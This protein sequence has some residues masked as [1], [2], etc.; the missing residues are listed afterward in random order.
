MKRAMKKL[1]EQRYWDS[2]HQQTG[3]AAS[4]PAKQARDGEA[5]VEATPGLKAKIKR[6]LGRDLLERMT[7]YDDY[8]LHEVILKTHLPETVAPV[9]FLEVGSAPGLNLVYINKT[10]GYD[11]YGIDYSEVGVKLNQQIFAANNINPENV[12]HADFFADSFQEQY[13]ESFH[14]VCSYG[15]IEHFTDTENVLDKHLNLLKPGGRL[16][17]SVPNLRGFNR[18][19]MTIFNK[20]NLDIHYL[21]LMKKERFRQAF[22]RPD[23]SPLLC[24]YYGT[25]NIYLCSPQQGSWLRLPLAALYKLQPLLNLTFRSAFGKRGAESGT[26]SPH[27]IFVGTKQ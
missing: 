1:S 8:L 16:I 2:V 7:N 11:T 3:Q 17:V 15:F 6:F 24:D 5:V 9:R 21:D 25:F 10:Y 19:L 27:L 23:L 18:V 22:T 4:S 26:F 13:R 20:E 12:I 14:M